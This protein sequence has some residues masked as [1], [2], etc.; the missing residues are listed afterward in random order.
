MKNI[1]KIFSMILAVLMLTST[2]AIGVNASA[3][4]AKK[5]TMLQ[6]TYLNLSFEKPE[7][8]SYKCKVTN[9]NSK[10]ITVDANNE[11]EYYWLTVRSNKE[12]KTAKPTITIYKEKDGKKITIKKYQFAV[13]PAYKIDMSDCKVNKGVEKKITLKNPYEKNYRL[14][15]NKKI[16]SIRQMLYADNKEY[17]FI[18]GL[19]KGKT[20]VKAYLQGTKK[21][22][23]SFTVSVGDY[24]ATVKKSYQEKTIYYNKHIKSRYLDGGS[25]SLVDAIS[26][27]HA[28]SVYTI[29]ASDST[30]A[31]YKT[32]PYSGYYV[33]PHSKFATVFSKKTG[34]VTLTVYE[35]RGKNK[36]KKIGTIKLTIKQAK[37][38]KVMSSNI[39]RDNDGI[40]YEFFICPG[41]SV[42]LKTIIVNR[43]INTSCSSFKSSEYSF[44]FKSD[45]PDVIS[46]DKNGRCT[47]LKNDNNYVSYTV[48]FSD[49]SKI[50][51]GGSF[52]IVDED[53]WS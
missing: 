33:D 7:N 29:K 4:E 41:E 53:F 23:G 19:K 36:K 37:D 32:E 51:G 34:K 49:G 20:T 6:Y 45:Y 3:V 10:Y 48:T 2:M 40:F 5:K 9:N 31:G 18:T 21:L 14:E 24:K 38:S 30:I 27:Y 17:H 50:S 43:Y 16:I 26:N 11:G 25:F 1:K 47:C 52:D 12:T 44:T 13:K 15:Y 35:K 28:D 46:V 8:E 39:E 42:D 22:I